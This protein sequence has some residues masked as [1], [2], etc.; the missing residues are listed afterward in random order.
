MYAGSLLD[1]VPRNCVL[2]RCIAMKREV[3]T[4]LVIV[5]HYPLLFV[6]DPN[7]YTRIHNHVLVE[8]YVYILNA[9]YRNIFQWR[10]TSVLILMS[11]REINS[12]LS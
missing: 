11:L 1:H 9:F 4:V 7:F 10:K 5:P 12:L 8:L 2:L 3:I 6:Y